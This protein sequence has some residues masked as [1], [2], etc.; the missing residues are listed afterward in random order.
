MKYIK[1]EIEELTYTSISP[2]F[3]DWSA[4]ETYSI[5]SDED[6][7]TSSSVV[8]VGNYYYRSI[9]SSNTNNPPLETLGIHWIKWDVSNRYAMVDLRSKT[10]SEVDNEDIVVEFLKGRID[11]L[12]VGNTIASSMKIEY[13]DINGDIL[14]E[15]TQE[16]FYSGNEGVNNFYDLTEVEYSTSIDRT[17]TVQI[18]NIGYKLRV[19]FGKSTVL[20]K[21]S[22][23]YLVCGR[24]YSMGST[25]DGVSVNYES[26]KPSTVDD[27]GTRI[28]GNGITRKEIPFQT[29]IEKEKTY[30]KI[31][32]A[33]K[34]YNEIVLF[35]ID[36]GEDSFFENIM[37]LGEITQAKPTYKNSSHNYIDWV[38]KENI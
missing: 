30:Q 32:E 34:A 6:N 31:T 7:L 17:T 19:T 18:W 13:L 35:V 20:N 37:V 12:G 22:V 16:Y 3:N 10:Y 11:V 29:I 2:R 8:L 36:D 15:Y 23:G 4:T 1:Q 21:T 38:I 5:E 14:T 24:G 27:F 26:F 33:Q 9:S 25:M 28:A